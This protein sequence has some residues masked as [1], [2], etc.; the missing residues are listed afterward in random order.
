M[1]LYVERQNKE[2]DMEEYLHSWNYKYK[3]SQEPS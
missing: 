2:E 1:R 3:G